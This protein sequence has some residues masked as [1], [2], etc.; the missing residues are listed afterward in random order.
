[1]KKAPQSSPE[2][3]KPIIDWETQKF[4]SKCGK[5]I[6]IS[7][8]KC[9][10]CLAD[11]RGIKAIGK[12]DD[13]I[14]SIAKSALY[15]PTPKIRK[16]AV[17]TLG[18]FEETKVLGLLAYILLNDPDGEVRKEAA[19]E[20]GDMHHELSLEVLQQALEDDYD[21]VRLEAIE[22]LKKIKE[23][24]KRKAPEIKK[25]NPIPAIR[26]TATLPTKRPM[27][28]TEISG[29][30]TIGERL[31]E[32]IPWVFGS[33]L[34]KPKI[35]FPKVERRRFSMP[36]PSKSVGLIVIFI[37][38]F[39]LQ[40]GVVYLIVKDPPAL[41]ADGSGDAIFLY[42]SIHDSFIIEGI[43]A[44]ILIFCAS[45]GYIFLYQASKYVYNRKM[46]L[47]IIVFGVILIFIAF[48]ALQYMILCKVT[49]SACG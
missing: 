49:P 27:K 19:D 36:V 33:A 42:P 45:M 31:K 43:V 37:A 41:G 44:S 7:R 26:R 9:N 10:H 38:L 46:A 1:M 40:T 30:E 20:I 22:G 48:V 3:K 34:R 17:D 6:E 28:K 16:E 32:N 39:V 25:K 23:R 15:D 35:N 5:P 21:R 2:S 12:T 8:N 47:R 18:D 29:S 11:L 13:I 24:R 4:C 14:K